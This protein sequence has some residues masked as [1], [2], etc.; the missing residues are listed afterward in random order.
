MR[1]SILL[2]LLLLAIPASA[3][4]DTPG[5][6]AH[7]ALGVS[8]APNDTWMPRSGIAWDYAYQYLAGG[9]NTG[10]GW[11]TWND[12]GQF[13]L[14]Y[15]QGAAKNHYVP[16]LTYYMLLQ[17][18]GPCGG[19]D[20]A[21]KNLSHLNDAG[22]M[23][24]FFEDF[25]ALMQRLGGGAHDG[26][27]GYGGPAIVH[28]EPDLSRYA[29]QAV[30]DASHC[31]GFCAGSGNDPGLLKAAVAR[32]GNPAVAGYPDTYQGFNWALLH[33]RDLYAPN[34]RLAL[35][36]SDWATLHDVGLDADPNEDF[37]GLGA[38]AG[39]FAAL[40][41][42]AQAPRGTSSYDLLFND[43]SDR[44]AGYYSHVLGRQGVWWDRANQTLPNF[45]GW[46]QYVAGFAQAAG[47]PVMV[48]QIP[49]G[50]QYFRTENNTDGHYQDNRVEYFLDH[51]AE[52]R[53]AGIV[54]L[55]FGAGNGGSTVNTDGKHD[56]VT[57][58][59][60]IC[61]QEGTSGQ[62]IC[63]NHA[64]TVPDD[65]GGYLRLAAQRYYAAGPLPLCSPAACQPAALCSPSPVAAGEGEDEG[66]PR[67]GVCSAPLESAASLAAQP[68][69]AQAPVS[70][71]A[72]TVTLAA[73]AV[74]PARAAHG[75]QVTLSQMM[76][77]SAAGQFLVDYELYDQQGHKLWQT[78]Q[79]N[80]SLPTGQAVTKSAAYAAQL[81]PGVYTF[82]LGVF[83]P[84]WGSL[85]AWNDAAG[86]LTVT[87]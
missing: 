72:L 42:A 56:G 77:A 36:V 44:D 73:S 1:A 16:V 2:L 81:P 41:G 8:A 15:A 82:K 87:G 35:H 12:R 78:S 50:N 74:A 22:V 52:L 6:P 17:S 5:L 3:R 11:R 37:A 84:G 26:I 46:E 59:A 58:P 31:F 68:Q 29:M 33:L 47:K 4:A 19:C 14:W 55:L 32:S 86:T 21:Q 76:T 63:N 79:D 38:M 64:S 27:G 25:A 43:V 28:V 80:T 18:N 20:E 40:S 23:A 10:S 9:V 69:P 13:P 61:I 53:Q 57:N 67:A 70:S 34:V 71:P 62:P 60:P 39:K 51:V 85:Y 75:Q 49:I 83:T 65:D 66:T 24:A 7:F 54:G 30:L 48:W 45:H